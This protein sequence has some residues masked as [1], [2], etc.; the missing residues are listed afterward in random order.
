M[1]REGRGLDMPR[2]PP[3]GCN[4]KLALNGVNLSKAEKNSLMLHLRHTP[5]FQCGWKKNK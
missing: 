2:R 4:F 5:L 3:F 1:L